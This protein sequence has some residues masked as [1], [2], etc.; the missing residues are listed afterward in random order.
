FSTPANNPDAAPDYYSFDFGNA[1]V[2]VDDSSADTAADSAQLAFLD[3]D[4]GATMARWKFVVLHH[5]L[6]SD[7]GANLRANPTPLFDRNG[8]D[9]VFMGHVHGYERTL[10]LRAD[11]VTSPGD[12]TVYI[13]TGGGGA[14]LEPATPGPLTAY[15]ESIHHFVQVAVD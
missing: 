12:G 11:A 5:A 4:L 6:Y 1:H 10:P 15:T 3:S 14:A 13:T 2:V 7:G 9:L 8:I